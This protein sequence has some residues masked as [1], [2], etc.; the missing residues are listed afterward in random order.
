MI[1]GVVMPWMSKFNGH[2]ILDW[3][4]NFSFLKFFYAKYKLKYVKHKMH[5]F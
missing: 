3:K 5:T 4:A 1:A 2:V